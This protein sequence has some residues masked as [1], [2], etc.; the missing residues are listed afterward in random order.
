MRSALSK[1]RQQLSFDVLASRATAHGITADPIAH[2]W[3]CGT[4]GH[5]LCVCVLMMMMMR[6]TVCGQ[7]DTSV[8]TGSE[9]G[10]V[11][12]VN[13]YTFSVLSIGIGRVKDDWSQT[14]HTDDG[15]V[16]K[17]CFG[18]LLRKMLLRPAAFITRATGQA[19][20]R[21]AA[22]HACKSLNHLII[23]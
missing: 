18:N 4:H 5:S 12:S 1:E 16:M 7:G 22:H 17:L 19:C 13:S 6:V 2:G 20:R 8:A 15:D 14:H 10:V 11:S 23:S 9:L 21:L 3:R